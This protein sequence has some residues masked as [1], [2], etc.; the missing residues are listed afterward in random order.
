MVLIYFFPRAVENSNIQV[1]HTIPLQNSELQRS[2]SVNRSITPVG[3]LAFLKQKSSSLVRFLRFYLLS[4]GFILSIFA[5]E[6]PEEKPANAEEDDNGQ[7][8]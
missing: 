6:M 1:K 7:A 5:S 8:G 3:N 4:L 2:Y